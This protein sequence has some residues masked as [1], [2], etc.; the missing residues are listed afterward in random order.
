MN[1]ELA[2]VCCSAGRVVSSSQ[3]GAG[4][5]AD[6]TASCLPPAFLPERRHHLLNTSDIEAYRL[7]WHSLR[8]R[9]QHKLLV[10]K[11]GFDRRNSRA[12]K[13][14]ITVGGTA[15]VL[16]AN[17]RLAGSPSHQDAVVGAHTER[18]G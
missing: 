1:D 2:G 17:R 14:S 9:S 18:P 16:G 6:P 3:A 12:R 5:Y 15:P 11:Q 4:G 10:P 7:W 13:S 8:G